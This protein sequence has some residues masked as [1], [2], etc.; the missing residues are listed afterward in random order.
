MCCYYKQLLWVFFFNTPSFPFVN[1]YKKYKVPL[2]EVRVLF[3]NVKP[4]IFS[5]QLTGRKK[6]PFGA[7]WIRFFHIHT[8]SLF[9]S[10]IITFGHEPGLFEINN[11]HLINF[12]SLKSSLV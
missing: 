9:C 1:N 4:R 6:L 12:K 2:L 11:N 7:V 10:T 5:V 8:L 3:Q